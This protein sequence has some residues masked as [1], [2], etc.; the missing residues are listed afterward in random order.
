M[1]NPGPSGSQDILLRIG[2]WRPEFSVSSSG[3]DYHIRL[4]KN[5]VLKGWIHATYLGAIP[6][7]LSHG[8]GHDEARPVH[9]VPVSNQRDL[10]A[11][12]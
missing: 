5:L 8:A 6:I 11:I 4:T 2:R 1:M 12:Y 10:D 9:A 7:V 3:K